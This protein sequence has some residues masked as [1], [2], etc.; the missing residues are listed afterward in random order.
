MD[1]FIDT[2]VIY[3]DP[4]WKRNFPGLLLKAARDG[5]LNIYFA[6]VVLRE[7]RHNFE[8]QLDKEFISVGTSNSNVKKLSLNHTDII[9]PNKEQ[10]LADFD[11]Y[12]T[13]LFQS[14]NIIK[15]HSD[16]NMFD[17]ILERAVKRKKP[18]T[19]NRSE[20][21]DAVI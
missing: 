11:K 5:R 12:Y 7:L 15:L 19:D 21:K 17:D 13:D 4:F 2:S 3:T 16:K 9:V 14:K 6:D 1:I 10:Y 18:F 8:K 20:F